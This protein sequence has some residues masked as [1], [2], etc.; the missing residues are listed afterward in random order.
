MEKMDGFT[1]RQLDI[2]NAAQTI[3]ESVNTTATPEVISDLLLVAWREDGVGIEDLI[4]F[5]NLRLSA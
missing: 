4:P 3:L 1:Q 2:L 5:V